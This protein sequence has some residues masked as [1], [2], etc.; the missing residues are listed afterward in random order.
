[1]TFVLALFLII[2][3]VALSIFIS[4]IQNQKRI[5]EDQELIN[6]TSYVSEYMSKALRMAEKDPTGTCLGAV[7]DTYV[8]TH[9][10][11]GLSGACNGVKF[12]DQSDADACIEFYW[13]QDGGTGPFL[14]K[15]I[16]NGAP[17]QN[18]LS[19]K[20]L[21]KTT[22]FVINGDQS[23]RTASNQDYLQPRLTILMDIQTL[24]TQSPQEK[25]I[26]TTVSPR[27][28]NTP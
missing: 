26:Q 25:I 18:I 28:L 19:D 2:M 22:K 1:M 10:N 7:G 23:L 6:Q 11:S 24:N 20:F 9:C 8:L 4:M 3:A 14:L 27:N 17:N 16:K 15:E 13:G 5:L 21:V 12:M